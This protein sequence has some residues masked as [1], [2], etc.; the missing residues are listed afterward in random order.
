L[1]GF[2]MKHGNKLITFTAMDRIS[3]LLSKIKMNL[4]FLGGKVKENS[5]CMPMINNLEW[6]AVRLR[7][8]L[9]FI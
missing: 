2:A 5:I 6:G 8:G 9:H 1:E 3:Y 7:V 4:I